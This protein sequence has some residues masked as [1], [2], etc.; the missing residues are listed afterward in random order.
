MPDLEFNDASIVAL[1]GHEAGEDERPERL[2]QYYF[3]TDTY[4]RIM[5]DLPLRILVGHKGLGK[6]ALFQIALQDDRRDRVLSIKIQPDDI[7]NLKIDTEDF[8][9]AI[10]EWKDGLLNIMAEATFKSIDLKP[11]GAL[12]ASWIRTK[13][14][15]S[16]LAETFKPLIAEKA[17]LD[18]AKK[19]VLENF[20]AKKRLRVYLDDLDRGW[21]GTKNDIRRI[22][23]LLSAARDLASE[24]EGLQF[25][26]AL[27]SDVY[28][29]VRTSDESTDKIEGSIV[30][31]TWTNHEILAMLVKRILTFFG[32]EANEIEL[33]GKSQPE[34]ADKLSLVMA[35]KFHGAGKWR[36]TPMYKVL[37]SLIRRRPRDV[38]K[39]CTLAAHGARRSHSHRIESSHFQAIFDEYSQGRLQDT[40]NEYRSELPAIE[41]LLLGMKPT[42]KERQDGLRYTFDT[43]RLLQK[44]AKCTEQG[45]FKFASGKPAT[46][47]EL[48]NFL[49]K[50]NFLTARKQIESGKI[51]RRYFEEQRYLSSQFVDFGFEWEIHPAYWWALQPDDQMKIFD[52]LDISS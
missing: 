20:M 27:R 13:K 1:F 4:E 44:I 16:F 5:A 46:P 17:D 49:Y 15:A 35:E 33:V 2:K 38:V 45:G 36:D 8:L 11:T 10:R 34:L 9:R 47:H 41:R 23:A 26:I 29:L 39:L 32:R 12:D 3:K 22:S 30:W 7:V 19:A 48:A 52:D 31:L 37:M 50:I 25:R 21:S 24:H 51:E 43:T 6:S 18:P 42:R 14:I 40:I 28:F